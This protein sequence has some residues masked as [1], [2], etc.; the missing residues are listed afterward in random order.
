MWKSLLLATALVL[1]LLP[2][3]LEAQRGGSTGLVDRFDLLP[4]R[5][6]DQGAAVRVARFIHSTDAHI[7][8][9][10]APYPLRQ[11]SLDELG[12]PFDAA[13]RPQEEYT[14]EAFNSIIP[15]FNAHHRQDPVD[16]VVFTG[17]NIDN[18]L[19][20][21]A[22]RF[23][24]NLDGTYTTMGP[25]S[26]KAYKPDGQSAN[27]DDSS[28]DVTDAATSLP[29]AFKA[30]GYNV[31]L[32]P[33]LPWYVVFGNHDGLIQGNAPI[34]PSFQEAAARYGRYFVNQQE[35][36]SLFFDD[37]SL[38]GALALRDVCKRPPTRNPN[39]GH[40]FANA[41]A[42][43]CDADPDNDGYYGF[44]NG[45]FLHLV[46]D[47]MNDDFVQ[48]NGRFG[49]YYTPGTAAGAYAGGYA[50]GILDPIQFAWLKAALAANATRPIIVHA[51][52]TV[53]NFVPLPDGPARQAGYVS[54]PELTAELN[55]HANVLFY[56]GGHSHKHQI[57]AKTTFWN[58]ET[59]SLIDPPHE[60]RIME[61]YV[62]PNRT[63]YLEARR[64][65]VTFQRTLDLAK[66]D[67]QEEGDPQN[68]VGSTLDRDVR[69]WFALKEEVFEPIRA[70]LDR[71]VRASLEASEIVVEPGTTVEFRFTAQTQFTGAAPPPGTTYEL[72]VEEGY[73]SSLQSRVEALNVTG[74]N[75]SFRLNLTH[76][77]ETV[78]AV[79]YQGEDISGGR[80]ETSVFVAA[81]EEE[82]PTPGGRRIPVMAWVPIAAVA[83]V[84]SLRRLRGE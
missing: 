54:G 27:P 39:D 40:G 34:E 61:I 66:T 32:D 16:F 46:L 68:R 15:L 74:G 33:R 60:S 83:A 67:A 69:L 25:I 70:R 17:D 31:P 43:L 63:G 38:H 80:A 20:N 58:V 6:T 7:L 59:A 73:G 52:H 78:V 45:P 23:I 8:D 30:P 75:A 62:A 47:T 53:N 4:T 13:Q 36:I 84:A 65:P 41:G 79:V 9:D 48:A 28:K 1:V 3:G 57:Q 21:E 22:V 81:L 50:E 71:V 37:A 72:L 5:P 35:Y 64:I 11:E 77:G 12:P 24:D 76:P 42:R 56:I 51:H 26:K 82:A 44:Q 14:D 19:E 55:K 2:A 10:D 18:T 29:E 49:P